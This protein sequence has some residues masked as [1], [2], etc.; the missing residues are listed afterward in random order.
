MANQEFVFITVDQLA[1]LVDRTFRE[2]G[3]TDDAPIDGVMEREPSGWYG[4][5]L[6][7][8]YDG[9]TLV[10]GYYGGGA[11]G[12]INLQQDDISTSEAIIGFFSRDLDRKIDHNT[13][14]CVDAVD[15]F[16]AIKI[17]KGEI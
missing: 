2:F 15:Y 9:Q 7:G 17:M 1:D 14:V 16:E 8:I 6:S 5:C 13:L 10:F 4:V 12:F 3:F 11:I